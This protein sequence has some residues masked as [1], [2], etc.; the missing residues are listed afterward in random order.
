M[1]SL[2]PI[3]VLPFVLFPPIDNILARKIVWRLGGNIFRT[4]L[5]RNIVRI[6]IRTNKFARWF[7]IRFVCV[8]LGFALHVILC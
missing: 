3:D 5:C 4:E 1:N 2:S 8:C 7:R 6:M